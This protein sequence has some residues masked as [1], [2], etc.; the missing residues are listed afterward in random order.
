[1]RTDV[2]PASLLLSLW[3]LQSAR[4]LLWGPGKWRPAGLRYP[5][6]PPGVSSP[7]WRSGLALLRS[8]TTVDRC[9]KGTCPL[10]VVQS[11]SCVHLFV[12]PWTA[13]HQASLSFTTSQSF[14]KL[15][16]IDSMMPSNHLILCCPCL[17]L[18]SIF[19]SITAFCNESVL[20]ILWPKY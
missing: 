10:F 3:F 12:T 1:M 7:P 9:E 6:S 4:P 15:T 11:L 18:P 20:H 13:A 16:S 2:E 5:L 17:L 8:L 14:L 19:L